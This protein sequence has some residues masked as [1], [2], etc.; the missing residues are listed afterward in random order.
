MSSFTLAGSSGSNQTITNGNT[1]T[2]AA[3][4]GVTTTGGATDTVTIGLVKDPAAVAIAMSL[5]FG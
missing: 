3:G 2:I 4:S 5:I 1:L